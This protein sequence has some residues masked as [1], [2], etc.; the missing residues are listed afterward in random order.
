MEWTEII[1]AIIAAL[2]AVAGSAL[3]QSKTTAILQ[4]KLEALRG[5]V[6]TLSRRVDKHNDVQNRVLRAECK[7]EELEKELNQK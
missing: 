6:E 5:D 4:T 7:L 2:G 3:M 1:T